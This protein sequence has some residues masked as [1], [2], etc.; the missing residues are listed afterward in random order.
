MP[1]PVFRYTGALVVAGAVL[2]PLRARPN[3]IKK[4]PGEDHE[5]SALARR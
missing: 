1:N 4:S 2:L 5:V 3:A